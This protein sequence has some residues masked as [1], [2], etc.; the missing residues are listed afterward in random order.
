MKKAKWE[1]TYPMDYYANSSL[2]PWTVN[3]EVN[4]PVRV[5]KTRTDAGKKPAQV[6]S[7]SVEPDLCV[8]K[9]VDCCFDRKTVVIGQSGADTVNQGKENVAHSVCD[10]QSDHH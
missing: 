7:V 4:R 9:N 10:T 6:Q 3:N 5:R 1:K 8:S 2:G